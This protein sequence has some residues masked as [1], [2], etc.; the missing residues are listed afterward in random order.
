MSRL[1]LMIG[2]PGSGKSTLAQQLIA[3]FPHWRLISTDAIRAQLFGDEAVQGSW[4]LIWSELERQFRVAVGPIVREAPGN[5]VRTA[6]YDATNAVRQQ[7]RAAIELARAA[8]FTEIAGLWLDM[9]VELCLQ[10]NRQRRRQVPEEV[11][12]QMHRH[13]CDAPPSLPDGLDRLRRH[14]RIVL[15]R[16]VVL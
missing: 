15:P 5:R 3:A 13:L 2:I 9:P 12:L 11:I 8:G 10:R 14:T 16:H 6:I 7:R 1:I 4:P